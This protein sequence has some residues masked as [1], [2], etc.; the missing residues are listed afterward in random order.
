M[1]INQSYQSNQHYQSYQSIINSFIQYHIHL[2]NDINI[3][4]SKNPILC[5]SICLSG[6][7]NISCWL[8][9][10]GRLVFQYNQNNSPKVDSGNREIQEIGNK[11]IFLI[12][13][14]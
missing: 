14:Y 12:A 11:T 7:I 3:L 5:V 10:M 6:I 2:F 4:N 1:I 13:N 9:I 8:I